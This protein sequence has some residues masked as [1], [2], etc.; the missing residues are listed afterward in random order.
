[1]IIKLIPKC[2]F[3]SLRTLAEPAMPNRLQ[4]SHRGVEGVSIGGMYNSDT[5][6]YR[7]AHLLADLGWVDLD[8]G[9]FTTLLGQ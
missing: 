2:A 3:A 1:M 4:E 7:V 9:Y 5:N 6:L 8:L